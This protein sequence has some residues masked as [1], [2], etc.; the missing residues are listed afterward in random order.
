MF[1]T[2]GK[3]YTGDGELKTKVA[4][5]STWIDYGK[6][7]AVTVDRLLYL[8]VPSENKAELFYRLRSGYVQTGSNY[9]ASDD[10]GYVKASDVDYDYGP[11]M[12]DPANTASEAEAGKAVATSSDKAE[13][14]KLIDGNLLN[15][16]LYK[17]SSLGKQWDYAGVL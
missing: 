5:T 2:S 11:Q 3:I 15:S 13:L 6:G 1:N 17:L 9:S 10:A 14:Q 8:W 16:N 4:N 7:Q 12:V